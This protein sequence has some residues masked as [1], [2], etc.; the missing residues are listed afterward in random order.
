MAEEPS[1]H[2]VIRLT[3]LREPRAAHLIALIES[4]Y[5]EDVIRWTM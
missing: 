1:Q 5:C 2:I 3:L 4:Y